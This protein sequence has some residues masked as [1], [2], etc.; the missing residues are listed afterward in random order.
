MKTIKSILILI[1]LLFQSFL[2]PEENKSIKPQ[3][4]FQENEDD[5]NYI[6][7]RPWDFVLDKDLNI[8][9]MDTEDRII[10]IFDKNGKFVM[11]F[12]KKG[13]GPCEF[14]YLKNIQMLKDSLAIFEHSKVH[15]FTYDGK[16]IQSKKIEERADGFEVLYIPENR[17]LMFKADQI[18]RRFFLGLLNI[19]SNKMTEIAS[20]DARDRIFP[21]NDYSVFIMMDKRYVFDINNSGAVHYAFTEEY[22]VFYYKDG[23]SKLIIQENENRIPIPEV[24]REKMKQ[25]HKRGKISSQQSEYEEPDYEP[26]FFQSIIF[27]LTIDEKDNIWIRSNSKEFKG[28]TKYSKDGKR[29]ARYKLNHSNTK[30]LR[31]EVIRYGYFYL[32]EYDQETGLK[33]Y[34]ASID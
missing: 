34:R 5:P 14:Q 10:K 12:G 9:I 28:Y 23:I 16:C 22:K 30:A 20:F 3:L 24:D 33:V 21:Q 2:L 4:F 17:V 19:A 11:S 18:K 7:N 8:Y 6:F 25:Q 26:P 1:I 29:I 31:S 27:N 15:F 32:M 13:Q